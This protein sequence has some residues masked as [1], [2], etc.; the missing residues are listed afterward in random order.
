[1]QR[2]ELKAT[3]KPVQNYYAALRQFDNLGVTHETAVRSAFQGLLDHCACQLDW[4][5]TD[6]PHE[7]YLPPLPSVRSGAE[8]P[9][10]DRRCNAARR[11]GF[12]KQPGGRMG[13]ACGRVA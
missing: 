6:D 9:A 11:E 8:Y 4:T 10:R 5:L 1:M 3:H 2:L 12:L 7:H 13:M